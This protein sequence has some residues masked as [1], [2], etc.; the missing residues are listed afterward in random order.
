MKTLNTGY[1]RVSTPQCCEW[2]KVLAML[3][4]YIISEGFS[5]QL[6][7]EHFPTLFEEC[8]YFH[9]KKEIIYA[10]LCKDIMDVHAFNMGLISIKK[11]T[12]LVR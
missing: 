7:S 9:S 4:R 8:M 11:V 1:L 6:I 3:K 5:Y 12:R 10:R 2:V